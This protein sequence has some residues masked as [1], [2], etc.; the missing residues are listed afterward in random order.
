MSAQKLSSATSKGLNTSRDAGKLTVPGTVVLTACVKLSVTDDVSQKLERTRLAY[1]DACN[2]LVP[3]VR[4]HPEQRNW[5][6]FNLHHAA[7]R[8][9]RERI[10][11][12]GSQ[13]SCNAIRSVSSAYKTEMASHPR[14]S[15]D[16]PLKEIKFRNPSVHLDKN[17][18]SYQADGLTAT[19]AT[20][21]KRVQ[22]TLCPGKRQQELLG[23]G[24]V[25]ESN[26]V[27][28]VRSGKDSYWALHISVE[29]KQERLQG[30]TEITIGQI[31]G[32]DL[33]ENNPAAMSTGKVWKGGKIKDDRDRYLGHRARLQR[34]GSQSAR[35]HLRKASGRERRHVR[36]V[37]HCI[38]R[39]IVD[40]ASQHGIQVLV[41]EDLTHIRERIKAGKRVR[42]RLNRWPFRQLQEMIRY[43]AMLSGI[44]VMEVDPRYTSQTCSGCQAIGKR[45]K[46]RFTCSNCGLRAHSDLNA[47]RN[48][49][50]LGYLLMA[51]GLK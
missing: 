50:G 10:P 45:Q 37:N 39:Q 33:G 29:I 16:E 14:K 18:I 47:S 22:V 34:N 51:Q 2:F 38:S 3:F 12:L 49:Q 1:R 11:E 21:D 5:Q 32:V 31:A 42:S 44:G 40:Q 36:H 27:L 20:V 17:T 48:L 19:I 13:Y 30:L 23:L 41:L 8:Q 28:H 9:L 24:K 6:R 35:Q 46:H 26:L 43:K 7:Y 15:K 25:K 4:E